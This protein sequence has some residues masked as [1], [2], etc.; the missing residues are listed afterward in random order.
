M[1]ILEDSSNAQHVANGVVINGLLND[2]AKKI[3]VWQK[4]SGDLPRSVVAIDRW[5]DFNGAIHERMEVPVAP[6]VP[7]A[8]AE[9]APVVEAPAKTEAGKLRYE[10]LFAKGWKKLGSD[11]RPEYQALK[12]IY[13]SPTAGTDEE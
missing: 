7:G 9:V 4:A 12:K 3:L 5:E 10:E 13:G 11:E 1:N 2:P 8:V 6:K